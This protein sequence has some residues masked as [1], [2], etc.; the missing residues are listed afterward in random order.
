MIKKNLKKNI[1]A[2][3]QI[4]SH[5]NFKIPKKVL[6]NYIKYFLINFTNTIRD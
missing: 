1:C 6:I 4:S 3:I 5:I 2:K